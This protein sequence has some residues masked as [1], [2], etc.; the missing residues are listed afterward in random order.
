M[1]RE[2][3]KSNGSGRLSSDRSPADYRTRKTEII[4]MVSVLG[5][6]VAGHLNSIS[7]SKS[8]QASKRFD[9]TVGSMYRD[10]QGIK[11]YIT[12]EFERREKISDERYQ[13]IK[14]QLRDIKQDI[15]EL[16]VAE[17]NKK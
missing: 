6:A 9:S 3:K 17:L 7:K 8:V 11:E 15:R 10:D 13:G 5:L 1:E 2:S 4:S 14:L 16:R 12:K